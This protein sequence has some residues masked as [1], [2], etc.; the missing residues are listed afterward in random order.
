MNEVKHA[1]LN[2]RREEQDFL[3]VVD[4]LKERKGTFFRMGFR[5]YEK[6]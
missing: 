5:S 6:K 2:G 1:L 4:D 3:K